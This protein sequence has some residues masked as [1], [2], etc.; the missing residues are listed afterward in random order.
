MKKFF[1]VTC[2]IAFLLL[3]SCEPAATFDKPQPDNLNSLISFP[4]RLQGI[5][6]SADQ[7]SKLK[8]NES[9]I[10]RCYDLDIKEHKDSIGSNYKIIGDSLKKLSDGTSVKIKIEGDSVIQHVNWIDTLFSISADH[11]LKHFRGYYFL[12]SRYNENGWEVEKIALSKGILTIGSLSSKDDIQKLKEITEKADDTTS[13][14]FSLT[15]RQFKKF[16]RNN[17]F[18]DQEIFTRIKE[19]KG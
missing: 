12:N 19:I 7:A 11:I 2:L 1:V 8:I 14:Y 18:A 17:G 6:L 5:Y 13:T 15:K 10:I 3:D 9:L 4:K 16:I